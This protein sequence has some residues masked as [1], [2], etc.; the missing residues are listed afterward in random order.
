MEGKGSAGTASKSAQIS[1]LVQ[2]L[3]AGQIT[4]AELFD[5]LQQLQRQSGSSSSSTAVA[6]PPVPT[7][8]PVAPVALP[9]QGSSATASAVSLYMT[10][11]SYA[12]K[13]IDAMR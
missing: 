13:S 12:G 8:R 6:P 10:C 1:S 4:K 3:K 5:R 7:S 11:I 9:T 2:Q